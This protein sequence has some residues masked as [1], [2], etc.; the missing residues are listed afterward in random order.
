[1]RTVL[2]LLGI[3]FLLVLVGYGIGQLFWTRTSI[4]AW[5]SDEQRKEMQIKALETK[6]SFHFPFGS[7]LEFYQEKPGLQADC[8]FATVKFSSSQ[9]NE[10]LTRAPLSKI[11]FSS[12]YNHLGTNLNFTVPGWTPSTCK[13]FQSGKLLLN[14]REQVW[15]TFCFD[16]PEWVEAYIYIMST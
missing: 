5:A 12:E 11:V 4:V 14:E 16:N 3:L 9:W 15:M 13:N 10:Y 6:L 8:V 1:M 7:V 2:K